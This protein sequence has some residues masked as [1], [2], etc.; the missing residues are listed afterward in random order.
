MYPKVLLMGIHDAKCGGGV[1]AILQPK[2][3][4]C[5]IKSHIVGV[6]NIKFDQ[7]PP[8]LQSR[9]IKEDG[10]AKS[11]ADEGPF[12]WGHISNNVGNEE[13]FLAL[14]IICGDRYVIKGGKASEAWGWGGDGGGP[15][16]R[17]RREN[18]ASLLMQ[19]QCSSSFL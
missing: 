10:I 12:T 7:E 15:V 16:Y 1:V 13:Q 4:I 17:T 9:G 8:I 5:S 2:P 3:L 6:R 11:N 18:G 14:V 19:L